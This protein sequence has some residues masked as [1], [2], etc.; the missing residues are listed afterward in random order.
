MDARCSR[1]QRSQS[2]N[3]KTGRTNMVQ[4]D[5]N[6]VYCLRLI[7]PAGGPLGTVVVSD[8]INPEQY[9]NHNLGGGAWTVLNTTAGSS[10]TRALM[11]LPDDPAIIMIIG[12][13]S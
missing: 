7:R 2:I 10:Y 4:F 9:L 3:L 11:V 8:G 5:L 6:S 13:G 1:C 12:V